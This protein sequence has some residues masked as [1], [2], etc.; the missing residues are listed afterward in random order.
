MIILRYVYILLQS[1][2][3]S[4]SR[5]QNSCLATYNYKVIVVLR[6]KRIYVSKKILCHQSFRCQQEGCPELTQ[7]TITFA[8]RETDL[9][10]AMSDQFSIS[11]NEIYF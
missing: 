8:S 7:S 5:T 11:R 2:L 1:F 4:I 3:H 9:F 10:D 6:Y